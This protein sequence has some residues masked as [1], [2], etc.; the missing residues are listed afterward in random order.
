MH[1][2]K[3]FVQKTVK[4]EHKDLCSIE[5]KQKLCYLG[6]QQSE[7]DFLRFIFSILLVFDIITQHIKR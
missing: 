6:K 3:P 5:S 1:F 7:Y 4:L 2:I